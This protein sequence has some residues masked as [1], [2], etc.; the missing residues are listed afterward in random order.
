LVRLGIFRTV[1]LRYDVV[2]EQ[3]RNVVYTVQ[4][5]RRLNVSLL[6]GWGSYELAR[7]GIELEQHNVFGR[8]H[9]QRL[10]AVQSF[11]ATNF[12]YLYTM[13]EFVGERVDVFYNAFYLRRDEVSFTREE[14]GAGAGARTFIDLLQS[15]LYARYNYQILSAERIDVVEGPTNA[16]VGAITFELR[17]DRRDNPL[18]PHRGYRFSG[19]IETASEFLGGE[20]NYARLETQASYHQPLDEGRWLHFGFTHG[21]I[22]TVGPPS[23][24]LPFNKRFFPGGDSS[25]RGF[26]F[27]EATPRNAAGQNVGAETYMLG[28][29]EFEQALTD[30]WSFISFVD[31]LGFARRI[32]DYPFDEHLLSIGG[33]I[34]WKT[35]IGPV[36]LEYGHN[37]IRRTEDPSGT[38]HFSLGFPF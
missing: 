6:F 35:I 14:F 32:G 7:A 31:V 26:Q 8:A 38:I 33:G 28:N 11:R 13:P 19:Y 12:D 24:D 4:E 20:V 25:I 37:V 30:R 15:D 5:G 29:L 21:A 18:Y 36:R 1:D 22:F 17:H 2:D 3:T 27:G 23:E 10:R 16:A 9:H 34:R